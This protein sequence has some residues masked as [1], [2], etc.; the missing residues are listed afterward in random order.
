MAAAPAENSTKGRLNRPQKSSGV[1]LT[2]AY[3]LAAGWVANVKS[4]TPLKTYV[5]W[6]SFDS[7]I[8]KKRLLR[9]DANVRIGPLASD[10]R[11]GAADEPCEL[12]ET[13]ADTI[14]NEI[15][16]LVLEHQRQPAAL[17]A[18]MRRR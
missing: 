3:E 16:E 15:D 9:R 10:D 4:Q 13:A 7:N 1:D 5:C 12:L 8:G 17:A 2:F 18:K 6:W 11:S 14:G